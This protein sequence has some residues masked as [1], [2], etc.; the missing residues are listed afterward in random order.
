MRYC[1]PQIAQQVA[2]RDYAVVARG[3]DRDHNFINFAPAT[4][5]FAPANLALYDEIRIAQAAAMMNGV[6]DKKGMYA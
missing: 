4:E 5:L 3:A 6:Q 2:D 1:T